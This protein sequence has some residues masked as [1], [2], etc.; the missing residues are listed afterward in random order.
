MQTNDIT[1]PVIVMGQI[2]QAEIQTVNAR[3]LHAFLGVGKDFST[4]LKDRIEQYGFA[5]SVDF[6]CS[7]MLGSEGRGGHN[8]KDFHITLDMA[9]ELAMVERNEK[10]KQARQYFIE[11]ERRAKQPVDLMKALDDPA[12][13]R[14]ALAVK[15]DEVDKLRAINTELAPKAI[16]LDRIATADGSLCITDAAKSLQVRRKELIKMLQR[17]RWIYQ[18]PGVT[19]WRAYD[20]KRFAGLMEHKQH[21]DEDRFGD[22]T[23]TQ[24]RVTPKGLV[25]L[26]EALG[27]GPMQ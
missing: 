23:F 26:A 13:L 27:M 24:A 21:T 8:R 16:A 15:N 22:R 11:C 25:K 12:F 10:G 14:Q 7:P 3:D 6:V 1:F 9:K 4:W 17:M 5:E 2:G 20:D 19:G 18:R